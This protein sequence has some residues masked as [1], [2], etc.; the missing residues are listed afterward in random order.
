ASIQYSLLE[1]PTGN[2]WTGTDQ[3]SLSDLTNAIQ[4]RR[5]KFL[6]ETGAVLAHSQPV[7]APVASGRYAIADTIIDIRRCAFMDSGGSTWN[8][9]WRE[10]EWAIGAAT[11]MTWAGT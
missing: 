5:N 2:S 3:F 4:R 1:P 6:V 11:A 9:L 7:I 8:T 10:D